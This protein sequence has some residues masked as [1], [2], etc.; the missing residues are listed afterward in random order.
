M[1]ATSK[2]WIGA[3]LVILVSAL[4]MGKNLGDEPPKDSRTP[5][6]RG[7]RRLLYV[8]DPSSIANN[9]FP[10][11]V[12]ADDLRRWVDELADSGVDTFNQEVYNQCWTTY[13]NSRRFEY[14]P[15]PQHRRFLSLLEKGIQP[16]AILI[17][18]CH[19]RKLTF[20]AGFRMNDNH[21]GVGRFVRA[22]PDWVLREF[23][24]GELYK[25]SQPLDFT[26]AGPR[27]YVHDVIAEVV[28][29]FDVDGVELCFRDHGYFPAG[30]GRERAHLMTE[31][32]RRIRATLDDAGKAKRKK[33]LLGARVFSSL[34][35]CQNL[36]LDVPTWIAKGAIDYLCPQDVMYAD[37]NMPVAEFA[38]LTRASKC[39]LY[40]AI[41]P[42]TSARARNRLDGIP[43]STASCCA[44]AHMYYCAGADGV[45]VYNHFTTMWHAPFYPQAV[46]RLRV[47]GNPAAVA[48][49]ER[50]YIFD[51]T[52]GGLAYFGKDRTSTG[53]VKANRI[54]LDRTRNKAQGDYP[55]W[56]FEG[57]TRRERAT[58]LFRGFNLLGTDELEVALNGNIIAADALKRVGRGLPEQGRIDFRKG[59][60]PAF[61]TR[62]F[63]LKPSLI[64]RGENKLS[65]ALKK[66]D[67][68]ASGPIVIDEV[69]VFVQP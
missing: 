45:S 32:V 1:T 38:R 16:L 47:L 31:L 20:I 2:R 56:L 39:M 4:C 43:L 11:P 27:D 12:K 8:S 35:E 59:K 41:L 15:R 58:L 44:L 10:D 19:R 54:S 40:P 66:S 34:G 14:D 9:L 49:G 37:F 46:R 21:G 55:F 6:P 67:P 50:H 22:H 36:G 29:R 65:V 69:E 3:G 7:E 61:S 53:A 57:L 42:W 64:V 52:W 18:Q 24:E 60:E 5:A 25:A 17:E 33:L 26:F 13:W 48:A 30:K 68:Q 23:P 63:E 28:S 62:W 51:P